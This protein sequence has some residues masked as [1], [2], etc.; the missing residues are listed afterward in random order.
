MQMVYAYYKT[1]DTTLAKKEK[2]LFHSIS[3][4]HELYHSLLLLLVEVH[5]FAEKRIEFG[6]NK[7]R[8]SHEDIHPNTRF[9]DNL[10]LTQLTGN[11][12]LLEYASRNGLSWANHPETIKNLFKVITE[13][14]LYLEYMN[15]DTTDYESDK[16]F[17]AKLF[18]KVM[19]PVEE[20]YLLFEELSIYWND[21]AE[22]VISMVIKSIKA[23]EEEKG[24]EQ[25][26]LPEFKDAEDQDFVKRL[27]RKTIVNQEEYTDLIKKYT[28]NWDFERVAFMDIII[29][30]IA[31]AEM[32]EFSQIPV[33]VTLNEYIEVAKFYSTNKSGLFINGILDKVVD[34]LVKEKKIL[35]LDKNL[36]QKS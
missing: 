21:E 22:F 16:R 36:T 26:L 31:I 35:K 19:A 18:E 1:G 2:E 10:F 24:S 4:S 12:S 30:Q 23:F 8:P 15:S 11:G 13:S 9:I 34:E 14:A 32:V 6:R 27:F 20:L 25:E 33:R 28:K 17:V 7:K 5:A 3:K 29:M